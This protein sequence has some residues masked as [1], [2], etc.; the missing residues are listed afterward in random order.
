METCND[1]KSVVGKSV[2][3]LLKGIATRFAGT[4]VRISSTFL[5]RYLRAMSELD[6]LWRH[7]RRNRK[8]AY[9]QTFRSD[10]ASVTGSM[11]YH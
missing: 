8:V 4:A 10:I 5:K 2:L 3:Q 9:K 11:W 1:Q 7:L 6:C